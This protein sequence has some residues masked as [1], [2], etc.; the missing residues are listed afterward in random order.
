MRTTRLDPAEHD[1]LL[2]DV[3][4]LPHALAGALVSM[5]EDTAFSLCG[6]GFQDMTRIAGGDPGLWRDILLENREN[7]RDSLARL[8]ERLQQL[9][10]LLAA[11]DPASLEA[12][13]RSAADRREKMLKS[14][15]GDR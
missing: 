13:L 11:E 3:S 9:D 5:Q 4:H 1:R 14:R 6:R 10:G 2:A 8:V 12:W 15:N 7:V